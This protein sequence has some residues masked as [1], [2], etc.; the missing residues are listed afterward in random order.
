MKMSIQE[1]Y[2]LYLKYPTVCT[3]TRTISE[4]CLFFALKGDNFN[5][6]TFAAEALKKGA[7]YCIIDEAP[8]EANQCI[9]VG[10]VLKTLQDLARHHRDQLNIPIIGMTGSNGKTT[11]K[12]LMQAA[13]SATYA[14]QAT[15]GNLNNHIGVPLTVLSIL[16]RHE[17]A[18]IEMGANHQKEIEFLCTIAKPDIGYITNYGKAHMEGFG[19]VEGIIKGKS[20]LYDYLRANGKKALINLLDAKQI[21][22][23][24]GIPSITFGANAADYQFSEH[25]EALH[26]L[27]GINYQGEI[28][29]TQLTGNYNYVNLCAAVALGLYFDVPF[30]KQKVTLEQYTPSNN[31]SQIKTTEKNVLV[32]DAYNAN[33]SSMAAALE[34]FYLFKATSKWLILGDMFEIGA[35][36]LEEHKTIL[37]L[38]I[39]RD[40]EKILVA[41]EAFY[42]ASKDFSNS[43]L[44]AF[45]TTKQLL[46]WLQKENVKDKTILIKGSRG[47]KLE[48]AEPLL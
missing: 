7:A 11:T 19:G 29:Q 45:T 41:G 10:D 14:T 47:M 42:Q 20:E 2:Q 30:Q 25:R 24:I 37:T 3:D 22:K 26:N 33:P 28:L 21:E 6:N 44:V 13:L 17:I 16:P 15:K 5:G 39:A 40:F 4:N 34:N 46:D 18:I 12:E 8:F 23:S 9:L 27:V 1:L 38:A 35:T 48:Q 36:T 43:K 32:L 31:R